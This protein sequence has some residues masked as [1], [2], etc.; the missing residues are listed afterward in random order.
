MRREVERF[1]FHPEET[2]AVCAAMD[3][4]LQAGDG[5]IN[6]LPGVVEEDAPQPSAGF[7]AIFGQRSSG[8][9]MAT[10]MPPRATKR[11]PGSV[12][13]GIMH[14]MGSRV[15]RP[16]A[17]SGM[18]L[19]AGWRVDQDHPRRGVIVLAP[20]YE[21]H[22]VELAWVLGAVSTLTT[23]RQTGDWQAEVHRPV[24]DGSGRPAGPDPDARSG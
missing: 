5:W 14:S 23:V 8:V 1:E 17:A 16:L 12:S 10:W 2:A 21:H 22:D 15:L 9:A 13:I 4:L 18:A 6:L 3:V 20:P 24:A 11:G 19:P 7:F